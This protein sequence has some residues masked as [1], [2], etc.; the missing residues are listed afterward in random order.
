MFIAALFTVAK[1]WKQPRCP[2]TDEWVK[3][4]WYLYTMEFYSAMKMNEILSFAGKWVELEN[5]LSEVSQAQ[6]TKNCMF[7]L[8]FGLY[9]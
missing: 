4:M 3:K 5:I 9:I 1:L 7:S 8:I 2:T 6:K